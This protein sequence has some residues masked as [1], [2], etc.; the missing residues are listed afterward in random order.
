MNKESAYEFGLEDASGL[1]QGAFGPGCW[2]WWGTVNIPLDVWTHVAVGTDQTF[3]KHFVNGD[4]V[5][6][7]SCPG[8]LTVNDE[9]FK[10][11]ARGGNAGHS[12][13]FRGSV[14][15]AML[16]SRCLSAA[17]VHTVFAGFAGD[18]G[19]YAG[20]GSCGGPSGG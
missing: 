18:G 1:L 7:D 2:R 10:I 5:E 11:G 3:E 19:G 14:D 8:A 6:Q 4:F 17:E 13:Q 20:G 15:E 16:W 12:S 9:Q